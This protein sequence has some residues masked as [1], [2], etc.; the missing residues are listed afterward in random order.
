L[1]KDAE[2]EMN[3]RRV[4]IGVLLESDSIDMPDVCGKKKKTT[5]PTQRN[6][7]NHLLCTEVLVRAAIHIEVDDRPMDPDYFWKALDLTTTEVKGL[8][9][10]VNN[11]EALGNQVHRDARITNT[12]VNILEQLPQT[13]TG[14]SEN[15]DNA[16]DDGRSIFS[17]EPSSSDD[18]N[19]GDNNL[20]NIE[21]SQLRVLTPLNRVMMRMQL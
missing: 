20:N 14:S 17:D 19:A 15:N 7:S 11:P 5:K 3:E 8:S 10:D 12:V 13:R 21:I 2:R 9:K 1:R 16:L 6:R 4:E 18:D